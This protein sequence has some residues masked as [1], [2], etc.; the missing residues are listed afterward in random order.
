MRGFVAGLLVGAA[1]GAAG[2]WTWMSR[3]ATTGA[4]PRT[5][6][7]TL[8]GDPTNATR[9]VASRNDAGAFSS[10]VPAATRAPVAPP[11]PG[12][13]LPP[14]TGLDLEKAGL[15]ELLAALRGDIDDQGHLPGGVLADGVV[16]EISGRFP[17]YVF[18]PDLVKHLVP[19]AK[20]GY[21]PPWL[22]A[23]VER[24]SD[25]AALAEFARIV[26]SSDADDD[27]VLSSIGRVLR[28][29]GEG[30]PSDECARLL[31]ESDVVLRGRGV[32]LARYARETDV[33]GIG[34][35]AARDPDAR[36]RGWA[37]DEIH[38]LV[39]EEKRV[40]PDAFADVVVGALRDP[41]LYVQGAA[42]RALSAAG[43]KGADAAIAT[44]RRDGEVGDVESLV[45]AAVGAGRAGDVL[46]L[47]LGPDVARRVATALG[48]AAE[49]RPD[50]LRDAAPRLPEL[51]VAVGAGENAS[52]FFVAVRKTL[53]TRPVVD[54]A[55]ARD[56][57]IDTRR[58][59]AHALVEDR[60]SWLEGHA[61]LE[62]VVADRG[63]SAAMRL[64]ALED[65]EDLFDGHA[66]TDEAAV[67]AEVR[68]FLTEV[69]R[70]ETND[71]VRAR[72]F[73]KLKEP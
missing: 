43:A 70:D 57:P 63:E 5:D 32:A 11:R 14:P 31:R 56:V 24:W 73:L 19:L 29:R 1:L 33:A 38:D 35:I 62:R 49:S 69:V 60:A 71:R 20:R 66:A 26:R 28:T 67:R 68:K 8:V 64:E 36:L 39:V 52:D 7:K 54:A 45:A 53:G 41:D 6:V 55:T 13:P 34:R 65:L 58:A 23:A 46:D 42:E 47:H 17:G 21:G 61:L 22:D 25:D 40:G 4:P 44:L 9:R 72:I 48:E 50:L 16:K 30:L 51:R 2:A 10:A 59:A 3:E 37:L 18:P 12:A 15:E 27:Y